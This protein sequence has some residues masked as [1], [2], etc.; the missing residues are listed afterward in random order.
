MIGF[1]IGVLVGAGA[2]LMIIGFLAV[3]AEDDENKP[4]PPDHMKWYM[5]DDGR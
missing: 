4:L 1:I 5:E 3:V 2:A